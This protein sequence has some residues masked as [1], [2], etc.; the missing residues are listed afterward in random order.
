MCMIGNFKEHGRAANK[1]AYRE[2]LVT[3]AG[4]L[5]PLNRNFGA[6]KVGMNTAK[7][8]GHGAAVL[9]SSA[10]NV[11]F[12]SWK[13]KATLSQKTCF[14]AE[15]NK[16]LAQIR[17]NGEIAIHEYGFR[18]QFAEVTA[19][20]TYPQKKY[21]SEYIGSNGRSQCDF[22]NMTKKEARAARTEDRKKAETSYAKHVASATIAAKRYGVPLVK[23]WEVRKKK[24]KVSA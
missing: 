8:A 3:A 23:K 20:Y 17:I 12:W 6:W 18:S 2:F 16:L 21:I 1:I 9:P 7:V 11:G 5:V 13:D 14:E 19:I 4:S 22:E 24:E 15:D 10:D